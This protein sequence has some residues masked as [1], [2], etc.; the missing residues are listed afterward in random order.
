MD[1]EGSLLPV[2]A[3][4]HLILQ[5]SSESFCIT[6][7]H[8]KQVALFHRNIYLFFFSCGPIIF[9]LHVHKEDPV[10]TAVLLSILSV[11]QLSPLMKVTAKEAEGIVRQ[12][13][14]F[15]SK[16][17]RREGLLGQHSWML[18]PFAM[19]LTLFNVFHLYQ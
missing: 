5:I 18:K 13:C 11:H 12:G 2:V 9:Y 8:I 17:N 14:S 15:G 3:A 1:P 6:N 19:V 10:L 7:Q 4:C 16:L